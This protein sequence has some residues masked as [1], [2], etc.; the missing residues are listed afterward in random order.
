MDSYPKIFTIKK[1]EQKS[2]IAEIPNAR[3]LVITHINSEK[4]IIN[5]Y[6]ERS[7]DTY[8]YVQKR[9]IGYKKRTIEYRNDGA[10][11]FSQYFFAYDNIAG[12]KDLKIKVELI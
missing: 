3:S 2:E 11:L 8:G 9:F 7:D 1:G 10:T 4:E 12:T 6:L 5:L